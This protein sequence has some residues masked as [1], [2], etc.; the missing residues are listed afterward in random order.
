MFRIVPLMLDLA[1]LD[2]LKQVDAISKIHNALCAEYITIWA[3]TDCIRNIQHALG[4]AIEILQFH[5]LSVGRQCTIHKSELV[6]VR[7][8]QPARTFEPL[9]LHL[10]DQDI[11][12]SFSIKIF[13]LKIRANT[14][15]E[16]TISK[17][18]KAFT[19]GTPVLRRMSIRHQGLKE[20]D[21]I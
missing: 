20:Q 12:P 15:N 11:N 19:Q 8:H 9:F 14:R 17:L 3:D 2:V 21:I 16:V 7:K 4:S 6:I 13:G 5:A 1:L 18:S 10:N